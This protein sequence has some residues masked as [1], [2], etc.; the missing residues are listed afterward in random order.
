MIII[1]IPKAIT[2][3]PFIN[4]LDTFLKERA[5]YPDSRKQR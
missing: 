2:A 3:W 4:L 1:G 5:T